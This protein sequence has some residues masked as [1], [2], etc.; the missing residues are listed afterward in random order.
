MVPNVR[1]TA[2]RSPL[3]Q[4]NIPQVA[5]PHTPLG[6]SQNQ[7]KSPASASSPSPAPQARSSGHSTSKYDGVEVICLDSDSE[8]EGSPCN[9]NISTSSVSTALQRPSQSAQYTSTTSPSATVSA[10]NTSTAENLILQ[11]RYSPVGTSAGTLLPGPRVISAPITGAIP[12]SS[13]LTSTI[14]DILAAAKAGGG[15]SDTRTRVVLSHAA[16]TQNSVIGTQ[17]RSPGN[18]IQAQTSRPTTAAP[19]LSPVTAQNWPSQ[20][21]AVSSLQQ[22]QRS[23]IESL[24]PPPPP[25]QVVPASGTP[26]VA[27][28]PKDA[29]PSPSRSPVRSPVSITSSLTTTHQTRVHIPKVVQLQTLGE[30]QQAT[31]SS[32]RSLDRSAMLASPTANEQQVSTTS[33][34][35]SPRQLMVASPKVTQ[36]ATS[37]S[38]ELSTATH[39]QVTSGSALSL[40]RSPRQQMVA[41]PKLT[42]Q[43][44]SSSLDFQQMLA[45]PTTVDQQVTSASTISLDR[46]PRQQVLPSPQQQA[47]ITY[48]DRSPRQQMLASYTGTQHQASTMFLDGSARQQMLPS[49]TSSQQQATGVPLDRSPRQ[50]TLPSPKSPSSTQL[51]SPGKPPTPRAGVSPTGNRK[52]SPPWSTQPPDSSYDPSSIPLLSPVTARLFQLSQTRDSASRSVS[53]SPASTPSPVPTASLPLPS[54]ASLSGKKTAVVPPYS[55]ITTSSPAVPNSNQP[56]P[57]PLVAFQSHGLKSLPQQAASNSLVPPRDLSLLGAATS[58]S[59]QSSIGRQR[60]SVLDLTDD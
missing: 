28:G 19:T 35:R 2:V 54:L 5:T 56:S 52:T 1:V 15:G 39:Q 42:Q 9:N 45:S 29:A 60:A 31:S 11:S 32:T 58:N 49:H 30:S 20:T 46:G 3:P 18:G 51:L 34:D 50:Q 10:S 24:S 4:G 37:S 47:T 40:D 6:S 17:V 38:L 13:A 41:S 26:A 23:P 22:R 33:L 59:V 16:Q 48:L 7:P 14:A 44:T 57:P 43:A 53:P 21:L 8:D 55:A 25:L 36:Q 12:P 27:Q